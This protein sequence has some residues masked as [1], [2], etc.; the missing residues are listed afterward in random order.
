MV[1]VTGEHGD[2]VQI[3]DSVV[4]GRT[5]LGITTCGNNDYSALASLDQEE[6]GKLIKALQAFV[7]HEG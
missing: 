6:L 2:I 5:H 4:V 1:I 3:T 7:I